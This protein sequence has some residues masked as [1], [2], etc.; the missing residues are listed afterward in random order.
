MSG[1][2]SN[3]ARHARGGTASPGLARGPVTRLIAWTALGVVALLPWTGPAT[4]G[5]SLE[6][7]VNSGTAILPIAWSPRAI[8]I[9]WVINEQGVVNNCDDGNPTC[10]GGV[11][12]VTLQRAIDSLQAGFDAWEAIP[13]STVTF[14]FAGTS[15]QSAIGLDALH[16]ITWADTNP[17][18]CGGGTVA[19]TPSTSLT[20]QLT[21]TDSNRDLNADGI[22]D[23]LPSI[24]P[25][26]TVLP[27]G[28]M[29]DADMAWC[30]ASNDYTDELIDTT[31]FTFDIVGVGTHE[32]GHF[33]GASHSSL[34]SPVSTLLPFVD[35]RA[36]FN[37]AIR[38][39]SPDDIASASR[40]YPAPGFATDLG[41]ITGQLRFPGT[42][43]PAAGVS[44]TAF[45]VATGEMT[46]QVFSVS[47]FTATSSAPGSFRIDGLPPGSYRVGIEY[48]D[49][50]TGI[51]GFGDADWWDNNRYNTT[52]FNG[53]VARGA[54]RPEFVSSPETGDDDLQ[55]AVVF[56]VAAGQTVNAGTAFINTIAPPPP[57][58]ATPLNL[59][60]GSAVQVLFPGGFTFPF[61]GQNWTS[62]YANDN[63]NL[64][65][66]A[67]STAAHTGNFLGPDVVSG[68]AVP[69]RIGLPMTNL[70]PSVDNRGQSGEELDVFARFVSD[71]Q[72]DRVEVIYLG[73]PVIG[74]RK[75][76]TV[77]ARLF[78]TGRIEIEYRFFSAWW[79]IVGLSPGGTGGAPFSEIDFSRQLPFSTSTGQA[80][81][82]HFVFSQP[83]NVGGASD[84]VDAFD[85]NGALLIFAPNA[86]GGYDI[87]SPDLAVA[88]PGIVQNARFETAALLAWDARAEAL[89]YAVYSGLVSDLVDADSDGV[90]DGY[91]ACFAPGLTTP[92]L[93]V[94]AAPAAGTA[95][96]FLITGRNA[97]GEGPFRAAGNG[98]P[99]PNASPCP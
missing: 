26:G 67:A 46:V 58:G 91:G 99:R 24:Y 76:S 53:N 39:L 11:S 57:A 71:A 73:T 68:G 96:F 17:S 31:T 22:V 83:S 48:F 77:I 95:R 97:G 47:Q 15:S 79:G 93:M 14:T 82:E 12:P 8:P 6:A 66:G 32:I 78:G 61:F 72:G 60:N 45:N 63:A 29:V 19:V 92:S 81:F 41:T 18:F 30:P 51:G 55:P 34:I 59:G 80:V 16:L 69:P 27:A 75:S 43:T 5:G 70:D 87:T 2:R 98:L 33:I 9:S 64:T 21:V 13:T 25:S 28:T 20:A 49:S 52:V 42:T 94:S 85:L 40:I 35:T 37:S 23:L 4:A 38:T 10:V 50:T 89:N 74:T 7:I 88:P 90:A 36:N 84:L 54:A 56:D 62:V 1:R 44:V 3:P 65:F 86:A